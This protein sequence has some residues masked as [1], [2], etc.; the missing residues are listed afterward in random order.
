MDKLKKRIFFIFLIS[1][2]LCSVQS[3][4]A[5]EIDDA[6]ISD[7]IFDLSNDIET[8]DANSPSEALEISDTKVQEENEVLSAPNSDEALSAE[9]D[10]NFSALQR[11]I[12]NHADSITLDRDYRYDSFTDNLPGGIS[13]QK[14]FT[15]DGAGHTV[16]GK[17]LA[18]LFN[19]NGGGSS[20]KTY[21]IT[22]KNLNLII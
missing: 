22:L 8:V 4:A 17:S 16:D 7:D 11:E 15:L 3:I 19:L 18:R 6:G 14:N 13:I 20:T 2:I 1:I 9:S 21:T 12:N 10:G 5:A